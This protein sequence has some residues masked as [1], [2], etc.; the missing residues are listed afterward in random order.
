M[1]GFRLALRREAPVLDAAYRLPAGSEIEAAIND[2]KLAEWSRQY[3]VS[4]ERATHSSPEERNEHEIRASEA[5]AWL[6]SYHEL[7]QKKARLNVRLIHLQY[8]FDSML[9]RALVLQAT[10]GQVEAQY[11][12]SS[13]TAL[14]RDVTICREI[15]QELAGMI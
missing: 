7:D 5:A 3:L 1:I 13:I 10:L 8:V 11:L 12:E 4:S 2:A 14:R 6:R 9:G 15:R